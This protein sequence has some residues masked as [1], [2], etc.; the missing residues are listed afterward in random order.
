VCAQIAL[1]EHA[2]DD[3]VENGSAIT[4]EPRATKITNNSLTQREHIQK[5]QITKTFH[6]NKRHSWEEKRDEFEPCRDAERG[7]ARRDDD[8]EDERCRL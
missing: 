1:V 8:D 2:V 7:S 3:H 6:E 5:Q 4:N